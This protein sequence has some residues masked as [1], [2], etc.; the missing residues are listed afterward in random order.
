VLYTYTP[1]G[2][3]RSRMAERIGRFVP[4]EMTARNLN[5]ARKLAELAGQLAQAG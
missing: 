2:I 5:M 1:A 4:V 3:A